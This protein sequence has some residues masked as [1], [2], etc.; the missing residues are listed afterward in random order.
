MR[1]FC[2]IK[3]GEV[4]EFFLFFKCYCMRLKF[5]Y[6]LIAVICL[7]SNDISSD[8]KVTPQKNDMLDFESYMNKKVKNKKK[9]GGKREKLSIF[10]YMERDKCR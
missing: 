6:V 9:G 5:F 1:F 4:S 2:F 3:N 10:F 7:N 8:D